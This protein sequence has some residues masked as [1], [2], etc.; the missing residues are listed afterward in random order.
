MDAARK[1]YARNSDANLC[2]AS[3]IYRH[4]TMKEKCGGIS[5]RLVF[6]ENVKLVVNMCG[7][8]NSMMV[9]QKRQL[10]LQYDV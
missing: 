5:L 9:D 2:D 8:Q 4:S 6:E 10:M 1:G 3:L 7:L